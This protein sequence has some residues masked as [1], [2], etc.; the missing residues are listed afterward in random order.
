MNDDWRV[1]RP[2][3]WMAMLSIALILLVNPFYIG[4]LPGGVAIGLAARIQRRRR[5]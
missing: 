2:A 1:F 4:A 5:R 3:I